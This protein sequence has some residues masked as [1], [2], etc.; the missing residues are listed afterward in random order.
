MSN[1]G[2]IC[3]WVGGDGG[4]RDIV[5]NVISWCL[6]HFSCETPKRVIGQQCRPRSDAAE[7]T[8]S[9]LF[10]LKTGIFIKCSN[11]K[12]TRHPTVGNRLVQRVYGRRVHST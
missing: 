6:T 8:G 2:I 9:T 10:A 7:S 1:S 11:N 12:L 3:G 4:W 5:W